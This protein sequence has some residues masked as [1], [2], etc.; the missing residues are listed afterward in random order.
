MALTKAERERIVDNRMKIQ[1][2]AN[3]L[4]HI[5]PAKI[6]ELESIQDCLED[7][8]QNL[9]DALENSDPPAQ[10]KPN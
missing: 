7:A 6:D 8:D 9:K 3:S 10:R 4:A 1:S 2:V 5:D